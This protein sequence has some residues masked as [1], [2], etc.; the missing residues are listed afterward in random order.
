MDSTFC[1]QEGMWCAHDSQTRRVGD[2]SSLC[3]TMQF[4]RWM[5]DL[6]K[7]QEPNYIGLTLI[8]VF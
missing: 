5:H 3:T 1:R 2:R 4:K 6:A 8:G 7:N